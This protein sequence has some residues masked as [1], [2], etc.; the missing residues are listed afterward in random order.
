MALSA[1][2]IVRYQAGVGRIQGG[3]GF[4]MKENADFAFYDSVEAVNGYVAITGLQLARVFNTE[5]VLLGQSTSPYLSGTAFSVSH[6]ML[7]IHGGYVY[8]SGSTGNSLFGLT[9]PSATLGCRLVLNG[10]YL[11]TDANVSVTVTNTS[12]SNHLY[13]CRSAEV[14]SFEI[15]E[16]G[17]CTLVSLLDDNWTIVAGNITEHLE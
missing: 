14:S 13:N 5:L 10:D 16:G 9:L 7:S 8:F 1:T 17:S 11:S 15:S 3:T 4:Y 2:Q 12:L 6:T